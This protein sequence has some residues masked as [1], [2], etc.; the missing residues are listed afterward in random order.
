M[1]KARVRPASPLHPVS[2][3]PPSQHEKGKGT[4]LFAVCALASIPSPPSPGYLS[5]PLIPPF[6]FGR[7]RDDDKF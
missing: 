5:S 1:P 7:R 2:N 6:P 4:V 3:A